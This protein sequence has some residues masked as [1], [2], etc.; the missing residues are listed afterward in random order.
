MRALFDIV[1]GT[2]FPDGL[3]GELNTMIED[4]ITEA[5]RELAV[6]ERCLVVKLEDA[7]DASLG[8]DVGDIK[9]NNTQGAA[10]RVGSVLCVLPD[11]LQ[12]RI[13]VVLP[14]VGSSPSMEISVGTM[15]ALPQILQLRQK[16]GDVLANKLFSVG[17]PGASSAIEF[18]T[19]AA[20]IRA[21][22][23][24]HSGEPEKVAESNIEGIEGQQ[25]QQGKFQQYMLQ[26]C[27]KLLAAIGAHV[28]EVLK[29][30]SKALLRSLIQFEEKSRVPQ[31]VDVFK[32]YASDVGAGWAKKAPS[33]TKARKVSPKVLKLIDSQAVEELRDGHRAVVAAAKRFED[34]CSSLACLE[35]TYG[36]TVSAQS[37]KDQIDSTVNKKIELWKEPLG[38]N[39][40]PQGGRALGDLMAM[41][42]AWRDVDPGVEGR[43]S[44]VGK[45]LK[46]LHKNKFLHVSDGLNQLLQ[47]L[48]ES[49]P[50]AQEAT[51]ASSSRI[52]GS[53]LGIAANH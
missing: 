29:D 52:P 34:T 19:A 47:I 28:T 5:A 49:K 48:H 9:N 6:S 50:A 42:A 22:Y 51:Q 4:T 1:E 33:A 41:Q 2:P 30:E 40:F 13:S 11:S 32:A 8:V 26:V 38:E 18:L 53:A 45:A 3:L 43:P 21:Q 17:S 27:E 35:S 15:L 10:E 39:K 36:F 37:M 16:L 25:S 20:K 7:T 12:A 44:L 46:G 14:K 23:G 24:Q 31:V